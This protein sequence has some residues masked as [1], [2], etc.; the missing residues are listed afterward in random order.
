MAADPEGSRSLLAHWRAPVLRRIERDIADAHELIRSGMV[1]VERTRTLI[2]EIPD[3]AY[4]KYPAL[5]K[6]AVSA[7]LE[8]VLPASE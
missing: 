3:A 6:T 7:A 8:A 1:D 4:A 2:A 5:S